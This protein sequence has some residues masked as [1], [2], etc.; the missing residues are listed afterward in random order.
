LNSF[1]TVIAAPRIWPVNS[2]C[3]IKP[4]STTDGPD[5]TDF[6]SR[7]VRIAQLR[8][9]KLRG[10]RRLKPLKT[11]R[12]ESSDNRRHGRKR[13]KKSEAGMEGLGLAKWPPGWHAWAMQGLWKVG[14][15]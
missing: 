1:K 11:S 8:R 2:S 4:E 7:P 13:R 10:R 9:L 15:T 12:Y 3:F 6:L 5:V 14:N